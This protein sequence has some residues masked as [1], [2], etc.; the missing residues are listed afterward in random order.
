[1]SVIVT[2]LLFVFNL[3][4]KTGKI[5]K[6]DPN[7]NRGNRDIILYHDH[8]EDNPHDNYKHGIGVRDAHQS[9]NAIDIHR[10]Y[11]FEMPTDYEK[12]VDMRH[13]RNQRLAKY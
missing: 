6:V 4:P 12:G 3:D 1:M 5:R 13:I 10:N 11:K 7:E 8:G 2:M 9:A